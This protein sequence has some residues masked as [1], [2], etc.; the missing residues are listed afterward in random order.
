MKGSWIR[1]AIVGAILFSALTV[2][3][4]PQRTAIWVLPGSNQDHL[5]FGIS[6]RRNGE[7]AVVVDFLRISSCDAPSY[8][9]TAAVWL[10]DRTD[11]I[12]PPPTR[13]VYGQA[14]IGFRSEYGPAA[15]V[16]GCY[17]AAVPGTGATRFIVHED[18]TVSEAS[19]DR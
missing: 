10:L 7:R 2:L 9:S 16:A 4:C 18:G 5:E 6:D 12:P 15:L 3:A 17:R 14:P 8:G 11:D 1:A 19:T 13:I